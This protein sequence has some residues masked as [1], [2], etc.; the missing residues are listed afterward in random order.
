MHQPSTSSYSHT[1]W[2]TP[3]T[4]AAKTVQ[5]G[6]KLRVAQVLLVGKRHINQPSC[7]QPAIA[8]ALRFLNRSCN[9]V[10]RVLL[11]SCHPFTAGHHP[12]PHYS[13]YG[14]QVHAEFSWDCWMKVAGEKQPRNADLPDGSLN[15]WGTEWTRAKT[16]LLEEVNFLSAYFDHSAVS[17]WESWWHEWVGGEGA[18]WQRVILFS[19]QIMSNRTGAVSQSWWSFASW[20]SHSCCYR[21]C[22]VCRRW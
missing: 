22:S 13:M 3:S 19:R 9:E 4:I 10:K 6:F 1:A 16:G 2:F 5:A 12:K 11:F 15:K 14:L 7:N 17:V 20:V 21:Q 18:C 8:S